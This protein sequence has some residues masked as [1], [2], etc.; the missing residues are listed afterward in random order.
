MRIGQPLVHGHQTDLGPIAHEQEDEGEP[1]HHGV[2]FPGALIERAPE[3][4]G[5][6]IADDLLGREIGQNR[7]KQRQGDTDTAEDEVLPGRLHRLGC[8]V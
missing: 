7:A 3:Q 8:A 6:R 2:E 4:T 5:L 1:H